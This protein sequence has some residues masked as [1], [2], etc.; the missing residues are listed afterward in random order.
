MEASQFKQREIAFFIERHRLMKKYW[1]RKSKICAFSEIRPELQAA[2]E[3]VMLEAN[4][5]LDVTCC[6]ETESTK[7]RKMHLFEK[8]P[9]VQRMACILTPKWLVQAVDP[10]DEKS[11]PYAILHYLTQMHTGYHTMEAGK[12]LDIEEYGLDIT[13]QT[14]TMLQRGTVFIGLQQGE[15][16]DTFIQRLTQAVR[17]ANE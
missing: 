15:A 7:V 14:R 5:E 4:E 8:I 13:S 2:V 17:Q 9:Q 11:E 3:K 12:R 10:G 6:I 16:A 1:E